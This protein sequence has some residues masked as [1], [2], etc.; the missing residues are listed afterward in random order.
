MLKKKPAPN[1]GFLFAFLLK[2]SD[3]VVSLWYSMGMK[4]I[5]YALLCPKCG[6]PRY[7]GQSS[8]GM[9]RINDHMLG[10][11][12]DDGSTYKKHWVQSLLNQGL[13]PG[14]VIL[15][16]LP[17]DQHLDEAE[18]YWIAEMRRRGCPLTNLTDGGGGLRGYK[19]SPETIERRMVHVRGIPKSEETRAKISASLRGRPQLWAGQPVSEARKEALQNLHATPFTEEERSKMSASALERWAKPEERQAQAHRLTGHKQS[20]ETKNRRAASLRGRKHDPERIEK[21]AAARRRPIKDQH[22][23]VY[24]GVNAAAKQLGLSAGN[25]SMVLKG[26]YKQT[27]GLTFTFL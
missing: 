6:C 22:G 4:N 27:G 2:L 19:Q 7:V 8:H 1:A 10:M 13:R 25:I 15:L 11:G 14:W 26:K 17:D 20:Q 12:C 5:I 16:E 9:R 24:A 23:H 21:S 3:S 18:V